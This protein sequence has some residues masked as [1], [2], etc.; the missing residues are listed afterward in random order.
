[1]VFADL[2][3]SLVVNPGETKYAPRTARE[4]TALPR[5]AAD[6]VII[7][8]ASL[9]NAFK[10]LANHRSSR[11]STAVLTVESITN[12]YAGSDAQMRIRNC[13][14]NYVASYGTLYVVL[15]GDNTIVPDRDCYVS[16]YTDVEPAMPTDLYYSGLDGNWNNDGDA[17]YGEADYSGS[18]DEGDLAWDVIVGRIPVRTASQ[19]T[20]YIN[21]LITW[22]NNPNTNY[23]RKV[24]LGGMVAWDTYTSGNR[25]T[26]NVTNSDHH[27]QFN[28]PAHPSVSDSEMWD[29][30]LFR[31]RMRSNWVAGAR[32][33]GIFC[34][35]LTSWDTTTGGDYAQNY[36]NVRL[37]FNQG[38][39]HLFF[40]GHGAETAW[41]LETGDFDT[42]DATA[43]T[44]KTL[45]VYTDACLTGAFDTDEPSLSE[46]FLRNATG[47]ALAYM[48]CSRYG[49]GEPDAAPASNTSDGG[50]STV[51]AYKFYKRLY[52]S[53]NVTVGRA[54][55]MHKADMAG[56]CGVNDC[57]R[58]IQFGLNLQG[59]PAILPDV[60][61]GAVSNVAPVLNSIGG[62]NV[63][64]SN[65]LSFVVTA[66]EAEGNATRLWATN[67]PAG[68]TFPTVTNTYTITNTFNWTPTV[69][70]TWQVAFLAGDKDGTNS[71]QVVISVTV[72]GTGTS[73]N[74]IDENFDASTSVPAGW[75]DGGTANDT[76]AS[77][78]SSAPNCRALGAADTLQ[79]PAVNYPTQIV[80]YV[81]SSS[82]GEGQTASVDYNINGG[83]WVQIGTFV[84]SQTGN[85]ETFALTSSPNLSGTTNVAFRFNSSF[86]TWYLDNVLVTGLSGGEPPPA[87]TPPEL[88]PIGN[89]SITV[90][91]LL[92]FAVSATPTEGDTVTLTVSNKP[93]SAVFST[94]NENGTFTW[95]SPT[96]VGVYT[97]TFYAADN[98]GAASEQITITVSPAAG[99]TTGTVWIN[100]IHY[101]NAGTDTNE[102]VEVAGAAGTDLSSYSL[103]GYN[104]GD[105]LMYVSNGLSGTIDDEACGYGAAW[106]S[107]VGLQNGAPDGIA[108]VKNGTV[109]QFLSYEG[110]FVAGNG[111]ANGLS[112]TEIGASESIAPVI[113]Y[114]VQLGGT[115]TNYADFSWTGP[116][117]ASRGTLN[118]AQAITGCDSDSDGML[119]SWEIDTFGDKVTAG[120]GTDWDGDGLSDYGEY[121]AGTGA[122]DGDSA[123][124]MADQVIQP[125]GSANR[126][127]RWSSVSGHTYALLRWTNLLNTA[128]TIASGVSATQPMNTYTDAPPANVDPLFYRVRVD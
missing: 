21:K 12:T 116:T 96:P 26:D 53:N 84:V 93:A 122:T 14:S 55:A 117:D 64:V 34:D 6:Y 41:G 95:T 20:N 58:W 74:L 28:V 75:T 86:S 19:A 98:D 43:L 40:S 72:G 128:T 24:I 69:T 39:H 17:N 113:N 104:G 125:A 56:L 70:G 31:D 60:T 90:S 107:V 15:G 29:R 100:E 61:G 77:H 109:V 120:A 63:T 101:D 45:F 1:D 23:Y 108:L 49:W 123:L 89:K 46:A 27:L 7:T 67:L 25:P 94:T 85:I 127:I 76:L 59:D 73:T 5:G 8:R 65:L 71:E 79:T 16:V 106:F 36:T 57:E 92:S 121:M 50:P 112:S 35:T 119:D 110:T 2:V 68:A 66:T 102:G 44:N 54:F 88:A 81:D 99:G 80:F 37:K 126:I 62:K 87:G 52:E 91:N 105:T 103:I 114:S 4:T 82:G 11:F 30:R 48:G 97:C 18:S 78:Y 51:Y 13:I 3:N 33:I 124:T 22:E 32:T 10:T 111:P 115:G 118:A 47:G 83:S 38:W 9:T 42:T